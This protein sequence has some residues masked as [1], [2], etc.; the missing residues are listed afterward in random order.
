MDA[1]PPVADDFSTIVTE[2]PRSAA[3]RAVSNPATPAPTTVM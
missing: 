3:T 1:M 2:W